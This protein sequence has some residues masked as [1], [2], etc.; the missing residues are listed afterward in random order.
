MKINLPFQVEEWFYS[1][2][3]ITGY[4]LAR[5]NDI[6][7][8]VLELIGV[9]SNCKAQY[10]GK[11]FQNI[12]F[13]LSPEGAQDQEN[14]CGHDANT[15]VEQSQQENVQTMHEAILRSIHERFRLQQIELERI[16]NQCKEEKILESVSP[17]DGSKTKRVCVCTF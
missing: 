11:G 7:I 8:M 15:L 2:G 16:R 3:A 10:K 6:L 14:L 13:V 5:V 12:G 17:S 1:D 4:H 9:R